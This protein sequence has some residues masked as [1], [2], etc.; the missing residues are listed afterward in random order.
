M[1]SNHPLLITKGRVFE[2]RYVPDMLSSNILFIADHRSR[3]RDHT[4]FHD[5]ISSFYR[6][7]LFLYEVSVLCT[8]L[9]NHYHQFRILRTIVLA[10]PSI[11]FWLTPALIH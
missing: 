8:Y 11:S 2:A 4:R 3:Y 9:R 7:L 10:Y 6:S 5:P 1:E